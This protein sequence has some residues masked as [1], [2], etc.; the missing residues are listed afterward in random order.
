[1]VRSLLKSLCE[2]VERITVLG[3]EEHVEN[4]ARYRRA[5]AYESLAVTFTR[6]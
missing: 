1:V 3:A 4:E 6:R 2:R 5:V